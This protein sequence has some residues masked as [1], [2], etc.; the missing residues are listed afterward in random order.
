MAAELEGVP[1]FTDVIIHGNP[2]SFG[3]ENGPDVTPADLADVVRATPQ[4]V[5]RPLRLLS[6]SAGRLDDGAAQQLADEIGQPVMAATDIVHLVG[7]PGRVRM[8][9][10][11]NEW[12]NTGEWR[13]FYPRTRESGA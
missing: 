13:V 8:V 2:Y 4:L 9:V 5:G 11:P 7:R 1:G 6:C 10:G 12:T 3:S